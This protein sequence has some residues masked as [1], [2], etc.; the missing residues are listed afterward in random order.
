MVYRRDRVFSKTTKMEGGGVL[1]A[2]SHS[3]PSARVERWESSSEDLWVSVQINT[4]NSIMDIAVCA[5]YLPPPVKSEKL[6]YFL[7]KVDNVMGQTDNVIMAG[8]FNLGFIGWNS[9]DDKDAGMIPNNYNSTLGCSLVDFM[10]LN[11]LNQLNNIPNSDGRYLDLVMSNIP[12]ANVS[13]PLD[14]LCKLDPRHPNLLVTLQYCE[15]INLHPRERSDFNF[16][17]ANYE[18][19][20]SELQCVDWESKFKNCNNVNSMVAILYEELNTIIEKSVP[21]RS[22]KKSKY[23]KWFS[24][25]LHELLRKRCHKLID[26]CYGDYKTKIETGISQNSEVYHAS[27]GVPQGSHLGP[28]LFLV[29][30]DD[31]ARCIKHCKFNLFADDLKI[32]RAID[33]ISDMKLIQEDLDSIYNWCMSNAMALNVSKCYH[34]KFTK[35]KNPFPSTYNVNNIKLAEVDEIR[36]LGVTVDRQLKFTTHID[37]IVKKASQMLGFLRRN[38]KGFRLNYT[39][40][41]LYNALVRS[42]MESC[43][44]DQT[45]STGPPASSSH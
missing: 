25:S 33:S 43:G 6:S 37:N 28:V 23:P 21:K 13:V 24:H 44:A 3:I 41:L 10:S 19:I 20:A 14:L 42:V 40:K 5:V 32:Y 15:V 11:N 27:S 18:E 36:D 29:F 26:K 9:G 16:F 35:K 17:K 39:R 30:V 1:I 12:G 7:D 34:I 38:T 22:P 45:V 4:G 2:V 8:D 31:I